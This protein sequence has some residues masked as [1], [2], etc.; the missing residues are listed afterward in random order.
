MQQPKTKA[1][2]TTKELGAIE[3]TL[4]QEEILVKKYQNYAAMATD[5]ELKSQCQKIA[6]KHQGHMSTLLS[7]LG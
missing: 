4:A 1:K 7:M 6:K 3:D 5:P 2:L